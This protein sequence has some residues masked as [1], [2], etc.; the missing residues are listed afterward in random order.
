MGRQIRTGSSQLS[1]LDISSVAARQVWDSR[2]RPTVEAEV[3]LHGG[4][5]GRAIVPA[6]A[7]KGWP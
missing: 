5:L 4:A 2:G 3:A 7:S 6:G 1:D